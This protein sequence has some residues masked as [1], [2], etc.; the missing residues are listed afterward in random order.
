M[1]CSVTLEHSIETCITIYNAQKKA[2]CI[3]SFQII[4]E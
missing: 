1:Q 4:L 3:V 2:T